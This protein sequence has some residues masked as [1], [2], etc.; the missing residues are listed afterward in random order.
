MW[1]KWL[2]GDR[3]KF[4]VFLFVVYLAALSLYDVSQLAV[5]I[6]LERM[7]EKEVVHNLRH[8]PGMSGVTGE[9]HK[10]S[11]FSH[12]WGFTLLNFALVSFYNEC[13]IWHQSSVDEDSSTVGWLVYVNN[14]WKDVLLPLSDTG[15]PGIWT[16]PYIHYLA[17]LQCTEPNQSA[18]IF[19]AKRDIDEGKKNVYFLTDV[20]KTYSYYNLYFLLHL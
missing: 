2:W 4:N 13:Q 20:C 16:E 9:N 12:L 3:G 5:K 14:I 7:W 17:Y 1:P 18:E 10:T 19:Q 11:S 15:F 6:E 8:C